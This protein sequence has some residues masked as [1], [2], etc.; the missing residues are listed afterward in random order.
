MDLQEQLIYGQ[1][2][3]E[4]LGNPVW[5][6]VWSQ[7]ET[8]IMDRFSET[9]VSDVAA[10]QSLAQLKK[11][12]RNLRT[13]LENALTTGKMAEIQIRERS[14]AQEMAQAVMSTIGL[15]S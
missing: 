11:L 7:L 2:A 1:R 3:A 8:Q 12:S 5:K 4:I 14:R 9:P 15:R 6:D 13:S 10:L